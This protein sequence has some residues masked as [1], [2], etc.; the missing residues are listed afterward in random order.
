MGQLGEA[1]QDGSGGQATDEQR[2]HPAFR[3]SDSHALSSNGRSNDSELQ[4]GRGVNDADEAE[5]RKDEPQ[6]G[7]TQIW[8]PVAEDSAWGDFL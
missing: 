5:I 4:G 2:T 1:S 3:A 8:A 6:E 7:P